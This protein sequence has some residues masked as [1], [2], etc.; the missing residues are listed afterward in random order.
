MLKVTSKGKT[1]VEELKEERSKRGKNSR[2]KGSNYE[3]GIAKKFKEQYGVDMVR[4]PQSGGF[5]KKCEKAD[6]FRG[7]IVSADKDIEVLGHIEC[8]NTKSW[9]MPAWL[10]QAERDC[11]KGKI[12][13][14]IFHKANTSKDYVTLSLED[15]FNLVPKENIFK[16]K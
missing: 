8:K 11:P 10:K 13:M 3:R 1:N 6:D 4:T 9:S 16:E 15:F 7:D 2:N 14:V 5:A 12:P